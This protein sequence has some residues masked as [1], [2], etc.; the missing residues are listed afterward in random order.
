[1]PLLTNMTCF[2][3]YELYD[4]SPYVSLYQTNEHSRSFSLS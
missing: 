3:D 4:P 2:D 1:M